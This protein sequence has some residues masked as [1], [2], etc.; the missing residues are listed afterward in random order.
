MDMTIA[1]R[2]NDCSDIST[3]NDSSVSLDKGCSSGNWE[4]IWTET[5]IAAKFNELAH[6]KPHTKRLTSLRQPENDRQV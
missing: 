5:G 3:D 4:M 2:E 1:R 6:D